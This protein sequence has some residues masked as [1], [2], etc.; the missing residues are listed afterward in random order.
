MTNNPKIHLRYSHTDTGYCRVYYRE[1]AKP[2]RLYCIQ[3]EGNDI[4]IMYRC[5][6][7][8]WE[9]P[10]Y[11]VKLEQFTFPELPHHPDP[12]HKQINELTKP[13]RRKEYTHD[14]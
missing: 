3:D 2:R 7:D 12:M 10:D 6:D 13:H 1:I 11:P 9:E 8:D 5:S 14:Q 4:F